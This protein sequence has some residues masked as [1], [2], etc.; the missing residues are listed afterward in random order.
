MSMLIFIFITVFF[1]QTYSLNF[2]LKNDH[3]S[4]RN[5]FE[6]WNP[7]T[8]QTKKIYQNIIYKNETHLKLITDE[9]SKSAPI[10][11]AGESKQLKL[12]LAKASDGNAFILMGGDCAETFRE[13]STQ[14]VMNTY[15]ILLQMTLI[16]MY[17]TSKPIIKIGRMAGQ[18][19]KPR[20]A[21]TETII[22]D[23]ISIEVPSYRGDIINLETP[24]LHLREPNPDLML[25]AY[26]QSVQTMNLIRALSEGGYADIERIDKWNLNFVKQKNNIITKSYTKLSSDVKHAI[27]FIKATGSYD[28]NTI[29]KAK[30]YTAHEALLLPYEE[31]LTRVDSTT[32]KYY[33]C[34]AHMIWIGERTRQLDSA[35]IE[36]ARGISNPIGIKISEKCDPLELT[37]LVELINPSNEKGKIVIIT[38]MGK[39]INE[40]LPKIVQIINKKNLNVVWVCDPMHGN[41]I[42]LNNGLKTRL[43]KDIKKEFESFIKILQINRAYPAGIHLELTGKDVIECLNDK[44]HIPDNMI[45]SFESSCDPRLSASQC[46]ELAFSISNMYKNL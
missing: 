30:F 35:H 14:N 27:D 1:T 10:I 9:I 17:S 37:R 46:L 23:G 5:S 39:K 12:D 32:N 44:N 11:F 13:F 29:S 2:P 42:K 31:A 6:I 18:Y 40:F 34:S 16:L 38:R 33:D 24:N 7:S 45:S 15:R 26:Y 36:F 20:S 43:L 4:L 3:I 22:E 19:A 21:L 8:W 28:L 25:K 41:T